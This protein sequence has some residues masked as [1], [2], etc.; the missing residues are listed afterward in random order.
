MVKQKAIGKLITFYDQVAIS[1]TFF[2]FFCIDHHYPKVHW[3]PINLVRAGS[4]YYGDKALPAL[5]FPSTKLESETLF[6][7]NK[8]QIT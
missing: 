7:G 4:A 1:L 5:V 8:C 3:T 6:K 2:L